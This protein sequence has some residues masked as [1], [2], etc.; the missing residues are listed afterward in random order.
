M[1]MSIVD[2]KGNGCYGFRT[3]T[4][5]FNGGAIPIAKKAQ[6]NYRVETR[7]IHSLLSS[8]CKKKKKKKKKY[9]KARAP[10]YK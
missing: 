8:F 7:Y 10:I 1:C 5:I 9:S 6:V 4:V 2:P 3:L